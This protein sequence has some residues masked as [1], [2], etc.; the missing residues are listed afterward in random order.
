[1]WFLSREM[2]GEE[3]SQLYHPIKG[4]VPPDTDTLF[5]NW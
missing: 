5:S 4:L 1:M 3:D 2:I